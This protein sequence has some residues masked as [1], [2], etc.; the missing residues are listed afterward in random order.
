MRLI[1]LRQ[2]IA[3]EGRFEPDIEGGYKKILGTTTYNSN[4][5]LERTITR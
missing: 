1:K 2:L 4:R 3:Q 5:I